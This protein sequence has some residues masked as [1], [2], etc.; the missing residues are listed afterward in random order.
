MNETRQR[1]LK[2]IDLLETVREEVRTM[3]TMD[4]DPISDE[5]TEKTQKYLRLAAT[6][7]HLIVAEYTRATMS[8]GDFDA[9]VQRL[10]EP[11]EY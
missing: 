8:G 10:H 2:I 4:L 9:A 5:R 1:Y 11:Y 6:S 7:L 3:R